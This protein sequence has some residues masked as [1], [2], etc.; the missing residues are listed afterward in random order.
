MLG[1]TLID[2]VP[3]SYQGVE[4]YGLDDFRACLDPIDQNVTG[5]IVDELN[6][7]Y[8]KFFDHPVYKNMNYGT[9]E[10]I[11]YDYKLLSNSIQFYFY[12]DPDGSA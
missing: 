9:E 2:G 8:D 6:K 10:L 3:G 1:E 11:R 4:D 7:T 12:A 5:I